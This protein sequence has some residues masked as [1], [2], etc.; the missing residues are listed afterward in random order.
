MAGSRDEPLRAAALGAGLGLPP[1]SD[2]P[3]L[4][5]VGGMHLKIFFDVLFALE[6]PVS[7]RLEYLAFASLFGAGALSFAF[8]GLSRFA[9]RYR[10]WLGGLALILVAL[11]VR[12]GLAGH[13]TYWLSRDVFA[14]GWLSG[15]FVG[16]VRSRW[17]TI[18]RI[19]CVQFALL[20]AG[21]LALLFFSAPSWERDDLVWSPIYRMWSL[22]FPWEYLLLTANLGG[23]RRKALAVVGVGT[24]LFLAVLFN[25]R[26]PFASA[27]LLLGLRA[28]FARGQGFGLR[29]RLKLVLVSALLVSVGVGALL[30]YS[31]TRAALYQA[32][33]QLFVRFLQHGTVHETLLRDHR[34]EYEVQAVLAGTS[35]AELCI[36]QGF[37]ATI[38][39]PY[40]ISPTGRSGIVHN[41]I[42][43][44]VLKGGVFLVLYLAI[45]FVLL[46]RDAL[47]TRDP[48]AQACLAILLATAMTSI[49]HTFLNTNPAWGF[50]MLC[51]GYVM[52]GGAAPPQDP[53]APPGGDDGSE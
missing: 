53:E 20:T 36:G 28:F 40:E 45:A 41:G 50:K 31:R 38:P 34:L 21:C 47:R 13:E 6:L 11:F 19:L 43:N 7:P 4:V 52:A 27:V 33:S 8:Y 24:F 39:V 49:V 1:L 15:L 16:A 26:T 17:E 22:C 42:M 10:L 9:L 14:L 25:K 23:L 37:G 5:F 18:D 35:P 2:F 30:S 3:F 44:L 12:G 46:G 51:A 32:G 29:G 48:R